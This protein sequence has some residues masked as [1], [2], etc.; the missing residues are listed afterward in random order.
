MLEFRKSTA[1]QLIFGYAVMW[2]FLLLIRERPVI[3]Y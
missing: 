3:P 2:G 1:G